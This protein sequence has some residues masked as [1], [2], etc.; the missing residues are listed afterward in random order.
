M[1]VIEL[2][3][4]GFCE[5]VTKAIALAE[6][7]K[8]ENPSKEVFVL[9]MLVHNE[10]VI[11]TLEKKGIRVLSEEK[12][13]LEDA[14]EKIPFG[15]VLVYSAHGH[16]AVIEQAAAKR[17]LRTYDSTC[18]YVKENLLSI[19]AALLSGH[20]VIY[21]GQKGHLECLASL[22]LGPGVHLYDPSSPSAFSW[23]SLH[24]SKPL[25]NNQTTMSF[26]ELSSAHADILSHLPG[27]TIEDERCHSTTLRQQAIGKAP[28]D[29]DLFVILGSEK[30][31]NTAKLVEIAKVGFPHAL[32]IRALGL[33]EL[34]S[35]NLAGN[36]KAALASGASTDPATYKECASYLRSI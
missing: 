22:A 18:R 12:C 25:V 27:A 15:S 2:M 16:S 21:I 24:D 30:S 28:S 11:A 32:V 23:V 35:Y 33:R 17:G 9:G 31:N 19:K 20:E 10:E 14:I 6:R 3:P 13:S 4:N 7:A 34:T 29:V 5:G 26:L 1:D 8:N 36:K